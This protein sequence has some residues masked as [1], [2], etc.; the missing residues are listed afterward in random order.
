MKDMSEPS[1]FR[2]RALRRGEKPLTGGEKKYLAEWNASLESEQAVAEEREKNV[3]GSAKVMSAYNK[4]AAV[5]KH[6]DEVTNRI[7]QLEEA[8]ER[9]KRLASLAKSKMPIVQQK[10][11][12]VTKRVSAARDAYNAY[13]KEVDEEAA[14]IAAEKEKV[15]V[16]SEE[17][18]KAKEKPAV[19]ADKGVVSRLRHNIATAVVD[20]RNA[21]D[22][23]IK[24]YRMHDDNVYEAAASKTELK[25]LREQ[26]VELGKK[27]AEVKSAY[28]AALREQAVTP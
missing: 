21:E 12:E 2:K 17:A 24:V 14:K 11:A 15:S 18:E 22:E 6:Y 10:V 28:E 19:V 20:L 25:V 16:K 4:Y 7:A 9:H 23:A 13:L 27:L 26:K 3:Q 5:Q 1:F 8:Q